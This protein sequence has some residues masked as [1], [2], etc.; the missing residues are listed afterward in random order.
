MTG[1]ALNAD[2]KRV[3]LCGMQSKSMLQGCT[4]QCVNFGTDLKQDEGRKECRGC[5]RCSHVLEAVQ[6]GHSVIMIS[7]SNKN[8]WELALFWYSDVVQR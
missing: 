8:R 6:R 4:V 1:F 3:G 5:R 7:S 2:K